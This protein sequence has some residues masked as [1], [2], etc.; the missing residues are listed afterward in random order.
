MDEEGNPVAQATVCENWSLANGNPSPRRNSVTTDED[1]YFTWAVRGMQGRS[2]SRLSLV[3]FSADRQLAFAGNW[4][5]PQ[6]I[7]GQ[8]LSLAPSVHVRGKFTCRELGRDKTE[9]NVYIYDGD[10]SSL[11]ATSF[12]NGGDIDLRMPVGAYTFYIYG[13]DLYRLNHRFEIEPGA[14]EINLGE[15]DIL[16]SFS[17]KYRGQPI[18]EWTVT[19]ARGI[20]PQKTALA[21]FRGKW[22]LVEF[23]AHW[24]GP[25]VGRSLPQLMEFYDQHADRR[26]EY[27]ILAFHNDDAKNFE[28]YDQKIAPVVRGR[29]KGRELPFPVLLDAT[30]QTFTMFTISALPT[31]VLI[32]PE[33]QLY[34][35]GGAQLLERA[36]AGEL[37]PHIAR[38]FRDLTQRSEEELNDALWH[39]LPALV[40]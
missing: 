24:C 17:A 40:E 23:W 16:G 6:D 36:L 10:R 3:V 19:D 22:L 18:P 27:Q 28:E 15:V 30:D 7:D 11:L 39:R 5:S 13:S 9:A 26:S 35:E 37:T 2:A 29:W 34:G 8:T 20:D 33:G 25:C 32:D 21:D 1:G 12:G 38:P 4:A 31:V 14:T